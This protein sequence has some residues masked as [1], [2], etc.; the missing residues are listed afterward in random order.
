MRD[1]IKPI[2]LNQFKAMV[3]SPVLHP[4]EG[5]NRFYNLASGFWVYDELLS[6]LRRTGWIRFAPG[7][8]A[9]L[10]G[11]PHSDL[12]IKMLGM[13][14]G[15]D[16][17]YFCERGYYL[18]HERAMLEDFRAQGFDFVPQPLS[19]EESIR[20]LVDRCKV[21]PLQ[22]EMRVLRDDVLIMEFISGV[23]FATQTGCFLN[24]DINIVA[25]ENDVLKAM[26]AAMHEL[27]SELEKANSQQLLHN[28]PMPPNIIFT[29]GKDDDIR[30]R[31]V[32][33]E[34]AQNL[35]KPSP[36]YVSNSIT[37]LYLERDVPRNLNT[38]KYKKNLDQHL[39]HESI[40]MAEEIVKAGPQIRALADALDTVSI[41]IPFLGGIS[42][43]LGRAYRFL[44]GKG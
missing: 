20:F 40:S 24:Y 30:A 18:T 25:F 2:S 38:N 12:C 19:H 22:A 13:G 36:E 39:M 8:K 43:N 23:P 4:I 11:H 28:D 44:K 29:I 27:R 35:K 37:E 7:F 31:L 16:P 34:L 6:D 33:F 5:D 42:I 3:H 10:Y 9:G 32:D 17:L 41:S 15:D 21:S 14:V 26:L 1:T